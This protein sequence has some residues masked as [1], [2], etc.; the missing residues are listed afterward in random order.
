MAR[1]AIELWLEELSEHG[2]PIPEE[3][4]GAHPVKLGV[5]VRRPG[6]GYASSTPQKG[7]L[8]LRNPDDRPHEF[9]LDLG[10]AFELPRSAPTRYS[11]KN[12]WVED[13]A[14]GARTAEAGK[15]LQFALQPFELVVREA[16][17]SP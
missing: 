5:Q 8:M 10:A 16:I 4:G 11:L 1:E 15:P 3:R 13:A 14:Q 6:L 17:P 9:A 2:E 12:P 7:I